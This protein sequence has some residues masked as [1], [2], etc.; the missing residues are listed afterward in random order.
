MPTELGRLVPVF[1]TYEIAKGA[2]GATCTVMQSYV[3]S[4]GRPCSR[5]RARIRGPCLARPGEVSRA[6]ASAEPERDQ[7]RGQRPRPTCGAAP[8][9]RRAVHRRRQ[10]APLVADRRPGRAVPAALAWV[11]AYASM[12]CDRTPV[13]QGARGS[14]AA[15]GSACM[16]SMTAAG[17]SLSASPTRG[18][19]PKAWVLHVEQEHAY[20][21]RLVIGTGDE[22]VEAAGEE[23]HSHARG[24]EAR[25]WRFRLMCRTGRGCRRAPDFLPRWSQEVGCPEG[26]RGRSW[27]ERSHT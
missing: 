24:E 17:R 26:R 15:R 4:V 18:A 12:T 9:V 5:S 6:A 19:I 8:A 21:G 20:S 22:V 27:D 13:P 16:R 23:D 25:R 3:G 14:G 11:G 7:D 1:Q 10:C 2:V